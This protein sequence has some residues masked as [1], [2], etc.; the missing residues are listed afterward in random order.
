MLEKP[1]QHPKELNPYWK[2][3]GSGLPSDSS[4]SSTKI[5][6]RS[7]IRR[8]YKRALEQ[9]KQKNIPFKEIAEKQW[10]SVDKI[11]SLLRSAGIDPE[12]PDAS[13]PPGKK[14][15]LYSRSGYDLK[16][17]ERV[18]T[19]EF[20]KEVYTHK[21]IT[22]KS[23][24]RPGSKD[25]TLDVDAILPQ[26]SSK[27]DRVCEPLL[28]DKAMVADINSTQES[29]SFTP[30]PDEELVTEGMINAVSAKLIKAE[31]VGNKEKLK[32]LQQDLEDL[33]SRKKV[34]DSRKNVQDSQKSHSRE[35]KI[36]LLTKTD[37]FG[38]TMPAEIPSVNKGGGSAKGK[39][40]KRFGDED[41]SLRSLMEQE[42]NMTANDTYEA[43]AK[44]ASKFVRS[45][46]DD[47]VDDVLDTNI[48]S[49]PLVETEKMKQK[50]LLASRK[51]EETLEKCK[52]CIN[53]NHFKKHLLIAMGINTYLS[54]PSY[55]SLTDGHCL[56][57]PCEHTPCSLQMDENV[58]SEVKI[59]QKGLTRMFSDYGKD[60][61]FTECY[62]SSTRRAHMFIDCIP[63]SKEEGSMAPMYFKKAI[64]ESDRE[65]AQNK[66]L[67]D[68]RQKGLVNSI[69]L[70]LPYFFVDFN[71]EGGFAHV[72][73]DSSLFP[74]YFAKEV[75]GGLID[76][77]PRL[78]LKPQHESFDQQRKKASNMVEMWK[79]Y[80]WTE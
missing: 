48:K 55:Q 27:H 23:F 38:R 3:G 21:T 29:A 72:I 77:E 64:L 61:V 24:L 8:S 43:V 73:E 65:W 25:V 34:Q 60:V 40:K 62:T 80:I 68:T 19:L 47:I 70:G 33:R 53:S 16:Y 78:W 44:M 12:R 7:W 56:I 69:P 58:L 52:F 45:N 30:S 76:T 66:K 26:S 79:P 71:N 51:M 35:E 63:I 75:I 49:D 9:A 42:R 37:R 14:D 11:Y 57:V 6:G 54:V 20:N 28:E 32:R 18:K 15:Y 59:F 31:L 67:I 74:H 36:V 1:G 5:E 41:Y 2:D 4:E 22:S 10:G 46:P 39:S 50:L 17:E 13:L